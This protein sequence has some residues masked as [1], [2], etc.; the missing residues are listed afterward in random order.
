M[1]YG[2]VWPKPSL[3]K[4]NKIIGLVVVCFLLYLLRLTV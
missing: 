1:H 2:I 3:N 4:V